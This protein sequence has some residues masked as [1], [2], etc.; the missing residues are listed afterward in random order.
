VPLFQIT[1][2]PVKH[3]KEGMSDVLKIF[4]KKYHPFKFST[5]WIAPP[6]S[7]SDKNITPGTCLA[8]AKNIAP[9]P[10]NG[11]QSKTF[12]TLILLIDTLVVLFSAE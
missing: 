9:K 2:N 5:Y 6:P 7:T 3:K 1:I 8:L 4:Q 10:L 11:H 12:L